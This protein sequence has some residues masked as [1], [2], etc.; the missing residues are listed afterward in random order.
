MNQRTRARILIL[1]GGFGGL[2]AARALRRAPA[3]VTLVDRTNHHVFQPLLYQVAT[4][5]L[6][7]TDIAVPIRWVLRRQRNMSVL[8]GE[9]ERVDTREQRVWF[10]DGRAVPYDFL[11][12]ATGSRH[13]YFGHDEW[14][15]LAPGLKT[16]DDAREIRGRFLLAFEEAERCGDAQAQAEWMTFAVVGGGPTGV[17]LAG[18]IPEIARAMRR[19]FRRIDTTRTKVLLLEAGPRILP[20]FPQSLADRARRDLEELGAHIRTNA[21]VVGI[22]P[23]ALDIRATED[24]GSSVDGPHTG[25]QQVRARTIFWAAGNTAS[26]LAQSLS[27]P[28]DHAGRVQV[29]PDLSLPGLANVFV[30]G[31]LATLTDTAGVVVPAVA[32]AAI[33]E[34]KLAGENIRRLLLGQPTRAFRYFNKGNLATIGRAKA[35]ADFGSVRLTGLIAWIFWLFV[36]I[37]NLAGF[38]NR[39]S[40]LFQWAFAYFTYQR[41]MRL[42]TGV[43]VEAGRARC[44]PRPT[45]SPSAQ[46]RGRS[47]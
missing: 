36:H 23:D 46:D 11:I 39:V 12:I 6:A 43:D 17:E 24:L 7:A 35:I 18:M 8:L 1:G 30:V 42:I 9:A 37:L 33:Q 47:S 26:P 19:D 44:A 16:L 41:G 22:R 4:A 38:R 25:V 20:T 31:D 28:L 2:R 13:S 15:S 29:A 14:E 3:D 32:P 5:A 34:G 10:T 45:V 27:A 40:V 21:L